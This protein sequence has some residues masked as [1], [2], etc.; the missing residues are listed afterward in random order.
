MNILSTEQIIDAFARLKA[1]DPEKFYKACGYGDQG[2][3]A[4]RPFVSGSYE[5]GL[6]A[7]AKYAL[8]HLAQHDDCCAFRMEVSKA[9]LLNISALGDIRECINNDCQSYRA[10]IPYYTPKQA[11]SYAVG[12]ADALIER[13]KKAAR[14]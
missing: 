9:V 13:L 6:I 5:L 8:D 3:S 2:V 4:M 14:P 10:F 11:A 1:E 12:V 7:G